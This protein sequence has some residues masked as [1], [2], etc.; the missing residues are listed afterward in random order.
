MEFVGETNYRHISAIVLIGRIAPTLQQL[1]SLYYCTT[2]FIEFFST[3]KKKQFSL[4]YK[5]MYYYYCDWIRNT[6]I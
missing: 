4:V 2:I 3:I 1:S 5:K 6:S